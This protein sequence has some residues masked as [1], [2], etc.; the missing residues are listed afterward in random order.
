MNPHCAFT[1]SELTLFLLQYSEGL[2]QVVFGTLHNPQPGLCFILERSEEEKSHWARI[3][4]HF[5]DDK[6]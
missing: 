1:N 2:H 3:S 5:R 6:I 4:I